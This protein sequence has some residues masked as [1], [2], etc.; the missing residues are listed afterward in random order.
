M[1][2]VYVFVS[3]RGKQRKN[4]MLNVLIL[5]FNSQIPVGKCSEC[6]TS[7]LLKIMLSLV[8]VVK[9]AVLCIFHAHTV[10][11]SYTTIK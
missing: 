10:V 7:G 1:S 3:S 4:W 6:W 5:H 2:G 8:G 11:Q 9:G